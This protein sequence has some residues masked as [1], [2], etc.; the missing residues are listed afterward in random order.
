MFWHIAKAMALCVIKRVSQSSWD[1]S[2]SSWGPHLRA[3]LLD[4]HNYS[5]MHVRQALSWKGKLRI[6]RETYHCPPGCLLGCKEGVS[7]ASVMV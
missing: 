3:E 4:E 5:C 7:L 2:L 1:G 6:S